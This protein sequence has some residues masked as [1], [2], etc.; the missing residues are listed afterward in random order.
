MVLAWRKSK[1]LLSTAVDRAVLFERYHCVVDWRVAVG[2]DGQQ[3]VV[4]G[5][6]EVSVQVEVA[7]VGHVDDREL[8]GLGVVVDAQGAVVREGVDH[9]HL[10]GAGESLVAVGAHHGQFEAGVGGGDYI[11]DCVLPSAGTAVQAIG[12]VV[13]GQLY[14]VPVE[15][16]A[17]VG[18][19]V[20]VAAD[21]GAEVAEVILGQIVV[22]VVKA[23]HHVGAVY[24]QAH[25]TGA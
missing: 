2:V 6:R 15:G 19:P 18:Q 10:H 25:H 17:S 14:D 7:V 4:D 1:G 16:D 21:D 23:L 11:V 9:A 24:E 20:G 12:A 13:A 22:G 8:V 5:R 3:V